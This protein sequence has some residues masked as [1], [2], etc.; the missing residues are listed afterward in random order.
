MKK[1]LFT[2]SIV[3]FIIV[4]MLLM[5]TG[6]GGSQTS[7]KTPKEDSDA[8]QITI[9]FAQWGLLEKATEQAYKKIAEEFELANPNIK[10]EF[11]NFPYGDIKQQVLTMA[12]GGD[13]PDVVQVSSSWNNSLMESGYLAEL[14]DLFTKEFLDDFYPNVLEEGMKDGKLYILPWNVSPFILYYNKELFERAGLDPNSPP[15]TYDEMLAY[16][17][18]ISKLKDKEGNPVYGIGETTASVPISGASILRVMYS[19]GGDIWNEQGEVDVNTKNNIEAFKYLKTI[20]KNGYNPES[21]KLKDLRNLMAIE[22]L[23]MYFDQRWGISG[24]IAINPNI[25]AKIGATANP[26]TQFADGESTTEN[27]SLA[28]MSDCKHKDAAAKFI[29]FILSKEMIVYY[30]Q[31]VPF[32]SPRESIADVPELNDEL[33]KNAASGVEKIKPLKVKHPN[34]ENAYL[35]LASAA[36][37]VTIG[38]QSPEE[39]VKK[40]DEKLKQILK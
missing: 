23:G 15:K 14:D 33:N 22:R 34:M 39:V 4:S 17:E 19:F 18:K 32:F 5:I 10:I 3:F 29:E 1:N 31:F 38:G 28:I 35:E 20:Y 26:S 24:A 27:T 7:E 8:E 2:K 36:Q 37:A 9:R 21:A 13:A 12:A 30:Y 11:V 25:A 40:L 16:A 6:C